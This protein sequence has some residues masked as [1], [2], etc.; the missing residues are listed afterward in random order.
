[1][2]AESW[3]AWVDPLLRRRLER[4]SGLSAPARE[5]TDAAVA[6]LDISGFTTLAEALARSGPTG[7]ERLKSVLDRCFGT[8]AGLVDASEGLVL[9]FPGDAVLAFWPIPPGRDLSYV[10]RRAARCCLLAVEQIEAQTHPDGAR[11]QL[12]AAVAAGRAE[13][14]FV[15]GVDSR[16]ECLVGGS[17]LADLGVA[18]DRA[19][20]G[21][22]LLTP[23]AWG[24]AGQD[25]VGVAVDQTAYRLDH[26]TTPPDPTPAS[27]S[28]DSSAA[29]ADV[30]LRA[31]IPDAVLA[32]LDA[33]QTAWLAEFRP[34]TAMFVSLSN[35]RYDSADALDL[36]HRACAAVQTAVAR[37]G[38]SLNQ[39]LVD[40]KGTVL[41]AGWG[42]ALH[43]HEDDASRAVEA[44]LTMRAALHAI[45]CRASIGLASGRAFTGI[46]G[47]A[48]RREYAMVGDVVN[49]AA[50]LMQHAGDDIWCDERTRAA[51][52]QR[53]L[54][55][56]LPHVSLKGKAEPEA[57]F[58]PL[59]TKPRA[60][61]DSDDLIDRQ[62]ET[63]AL[64]GELRALESGDSREVV[65]LEGEPGIGKSRLIASLLR[66]TQTSNVRAVVGRGH[67]VERESAYHAW[68]EAFSRLLGLHADT[69]SPAHR[70]RVLSLLE[71]APDMAVHASLLNPVLSLG[72]PEDERTRQFTPQGRAET[73]RHL[74]LHLFAAVTRQLP[75][76][77]V[78]EDAH[79]LDSASWALADALASQIRPVLVVVS[80]RPVL[81]QD[82][83]PDCRRFLSR[84]QVT[85]LPL[86]TLA[87]DDAAALAGQCLGADALPR[88][89]TELVWHSA[90]G[91]P[92]YTEQLVLALR[93]SGVLR[94]DQG[95]CHLTATDLSA[96]A[97][98][99]T[100]QG[101]VTSRIDRLTPSQQMALK[102][103]S[104][105]GP[106]F[107]LT[108]LRELFPMTISPEQLRAD[109]DEMVAL[110]L[111]RAEPTGTDDYAFKHAI[112]RQVTYEMLP[113][114]QRRML[115]ATV[116]ARLEASD[117]A[118]NYPLIA[119]H[120]SGAGV[121]DKAFGALVAAGE[122]AARADV[123]PE[124]A[125]FFTAALALELPDRDSP[126]RRL[127]RARAHRQLG[128]VLWT[129]GDFDKVRAENHAGFALL[130]RGSW[131]E[132]GRVSLLVAQIAVQAWHLLAPRRTAGGNTLGTRRLIEASKTAALLARVRSAPLDAVGL[133]S[134]SLLALNLAERAGSVNVFA[135][136]M[137]GYTA[138]AMKLR[139]LSRRYFDRGR[140]EAF[141][142]NEL[143]DYTLMVP[144]DAMTRFG[145]GDHAGCV[146][147]CTEG[148]ELA[149]RIGERRA[150][151]RT[152]ALLAAANAFTLSGPAT[153]P[154]QQS[155]E[156][157]DSVRDQPAIEQAYYL[158]LRGTIISMLLP[159][160]DAAALFADVEALLDESLKHATDDAVALTFS[161]RALYYTRV[162]KLDDAG[163]AAERAFTWAR[164]RLRSVPPT[165]FV[166]LQGPVEAFLALYQR[167]LEGK[168][169]DLPA[170]TRRARASVA[171][172]GRWAGIYPI[173]DAR[174]RLF[175]G[176][177][178][179]L[180]GRGAQAQQRW[181][182]ALQAA[183]HLALPFDEAMTRLELSRHPDTPGA[184]R[185]VH[186][187]RAR[188]VLEPAGVSHILA[189][190]EGPFLSHR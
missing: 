33:G 69:T 104:V 173:Y 40:D 146:A 164:T 186:F 71:S 161:M 162:G 129:L 6:L 189:G 185:D 184:D 35:A 121:A 168:T 90:A 4:A 61:A 45:G 181:Q 144:Y 165:G 1:M 105:L 89:L 12:R 62:H 135:L 59:R 124:A 123:N 27:S 172:Y 112:T 179:S 60:G 178:A 111:L 47:N 2:H 101:V 93:D 88:R 22:V 118:H 158:G 85:R 54:F 128:E 53:T 17:P 46:R 106:T 183:E 34:V 152:T 28:D 157:L 131:W 57:V 143:S 182:L 91:H 95:E 30:A 3:R 188:Q 151:V 100:V 13:I 137:M 97:L 116:A 75:V 109:A 150:V 80:M 5:T 155:A 98:P 119:H 76:L 48:R 174:A 127:D 26:L 114:A 77:I 177:L 51:A 70:Q 169:P 21:D 190:A 133:L 139:G 86:E 49:L 156:T 63:A 92:F 39:S 148:R 187:A 43:A 120:W 9:K 142:L 122:E 78:L 79:W 99:D 163:H 44:A 176:R 180:E 19:R 74:L 64:F 130:V 72:L 107:E 125:R 32:H 55:E 117:A 25:A 8:L 94:V 65:I 134:A 132:R 167:A 159:P 37:F 108:T 41:L 136:G 73:L 153:E 56:R 67:P 149:R 140:H 147:L 15:G 66:H 82:M 14:L 84:A 16:W 36:L 166:L 171:A 170:A 50:R 102:I 52:R 154:L 103:G 11:L 24:A 141:A 160:S 10:V 29:A 23:D 110:S 96:L 38:G 18:L 126:E 7:T 68:R 175:E 115:H 138:G 42:L 20:P 83:T 58:R 81:P 31:C 145:T 113:F 87:S